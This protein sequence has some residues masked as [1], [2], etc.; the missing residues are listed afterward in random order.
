MNRWL[1][2]KRLAHAI[3]CGA[4]ALNT[5]VCS[6]GAMVSN[7]NAAKTID[8]I[9]QEVEKLKTN[10]VASDELARAKINMRSNE[11]YEKETV[12]GQGAKIASFIASSGEA[13]FER[14]YYQ[15]MAEVTPEYLR[16]G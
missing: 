15:R 10:F 9:S 13:S 4:Y 1:R 3:H 11:I 8:A 7:S 16:S 12:G 6:V 2:K 5:P 14:T